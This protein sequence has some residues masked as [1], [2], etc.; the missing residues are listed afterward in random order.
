MT[1]PAS[2]EPIL[3]AVVCAAVLSACGKQPPDAAVSVPALAVPGHGL[4]GMTLE[5]GWASG[6][7]LTCKCGAAF[8]TYR[9]SDAEAL[10]HYHKLEASN[11]NE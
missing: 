1:D 9:R 11:G 4:S 5:Q 6:W 8:A 7:T 2:R 10:W 3:L